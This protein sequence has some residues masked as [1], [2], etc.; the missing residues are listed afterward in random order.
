M[1][2][3]DDIGLEVMRAPDSDFEGS[4]DLQNNTEEQIYGN[5]RKNDQQKKSNPPKIFGRMTLIIYLISWR[6]IDPD[7]NIQDAWEKLTY[8]SQNAKLHCV[9]IQTKTDTRDFILNN[10]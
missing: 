1:P 6:W 8:Y 3:E 10:L 2:D 9:L 4:V 7:V 5:K